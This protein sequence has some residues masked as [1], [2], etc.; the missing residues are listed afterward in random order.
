MKWGQIVAVRHKRIKVVESNRQMNK[1]GKIVR[2]SPRYVLP[3]AEIAIEAEGFRIEGYASNGCSV[4][5]FACRLIAAS[6]SRILA[7]IPSEIG[8]SGELDVRLTSSTEESG[9]E[10]VVVAERL[11]DDMHIVANPAID[12]KDGSLV[13]TRSGG[14]GQELPNTLF[15]RE[16]DGFLDELPVK[17]LNPTGV[18]FDPDSELFV[19]NRNDGE[20]CRI[21][22]GEDAVPYA[23]GLGIATGLAFD[24]EGVMF[25]GDRSGTI[26]RIPA[27]GRVESFA[28]LEPSVAAYHLAF[29]PDGRLYVTAPG[30]ASFE[31]VFAID[32]LGNVEKYFRGL[33]R[34]QGIA[35]D[36]E[37]TLY[38]ASCY[39]GRHGITRISP[40]AKTA[41]HFVSGNNVVGLCFGK[42][43]DLLVA[44]NDSVFALPVNKKG[45]LL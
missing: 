31:S 40:D 13:L 32:T 28:T 16:P 41:E 37:G 18:A 8:S 36:S 5:G 14:R 1:A 43:G 24:R 10:T 34:P 22:R 6:S 25:V 7:E 30:L 27:P 12:P 42:E 2:V 20:V 38:V 26:Y 4:A 33:G 19:T 3:G 44:T 23:T 21:V 11:I 45:V 9:S 39:K 35:F 29:G 15:R 17:I